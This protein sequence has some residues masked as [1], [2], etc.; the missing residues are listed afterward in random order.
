M[1]KKSIYKPT[2]VL[3]LIKTNDQSYIADISYLFP[4]L[5]AFEKLW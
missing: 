3:I 2:F 1:E 4:L 5:R